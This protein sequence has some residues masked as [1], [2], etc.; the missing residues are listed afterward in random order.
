MGS[1]P[2]GAWK[3]AGSL[4]LCK[5]VSELR[6]ALEEV[7]HER[8][9]FVPTMGAL[10]KGHL[11]LV[12]AAQQRGDQVVVSIFVN[13]LQFGPGE[14]LDSYPRT[15]K[16]DLELLEQAGVPLVFLPGMEEMYPPGAGTFVEVEGIS[17]DLEGRLRPHHFRGVA[18][19][20]ARLFHLVQPVRGYF[21]WKDMQQVC[22]LKKMVRDLGFPLEIVPCEIVRE[23]DGLALSSRNRFLKAEQRAAAST[24]SLGLRRACQAFLEGE[25]SLAQLQSIARAS[26]ADLLQCEYIAVR[27][28]ED[29]SDPGER[30]EGGR[31]LGAVRLGGVHLID[32]MALG[33]K[34][35]G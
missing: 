35:E 11:S 22:L 21:G 25:R 12:H 29:F 34:T 9:G 15:E 23:E 8:R 33:E 31:I 20:C 1:S 4:I 10:H 18:T 19:V 6:N 7:P 32:N 2:S 3:V 17:K 24:L 27:R 13:P 16:K 14:D 26:L 30:V 28:S 5:T